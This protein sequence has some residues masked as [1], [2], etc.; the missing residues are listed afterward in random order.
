MATQ[1][2]RLLDLDTCADHLLNRFV[3]FFDQLRLWLFRI[4]YSFSGFRMT[5]SSPDSDMGQSQLQLFQAPNP[6]EPPEG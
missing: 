3:H 4:H 6:A 2:N 5:N 1:L